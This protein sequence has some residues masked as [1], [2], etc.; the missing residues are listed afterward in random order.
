MSIAIVI[1][2]I[3]IVYQSL[4]DFTSATNNARLATFFWAFS[5]V[6]AGL[7]ARFFTT[8][9]Q[10]E[11]ES[12][13]RARY[14]IRDIIFNRTFLSLFPILLLALVLRVVPIMNRGLQ[15]DEWYWLDSAKYILKGVVVSPF[16]FIGD[17]PT[18]LPAYP[19][20][21][22]LLIVRNA[23][24]AVRLIGVI[25]SLIAISLVYFFVKKT[26]GFTAAVCGALLMT[27][28][29]WDIHMS[30][31]GYLNVNIS[32]MLV[33]AILFLLHQVWEQKY[34]FWTLFGLA[35]LTAICIHLL[36]VPTFLAVPVGLVLLI[37]WMRRHNGRRMKEI[38]LFGLFFFIVMSPIIQKVI[39]YPDTISRHSDYLQQ[40]LHLSSEAET[41][42]DYYLGQFIL[43]HKDYIKGD[44]NVG[45][46][47]LWGIT[48]D[49]LVLAL[50]MAGNILIV[51]QV[52]RK[53]SHPFWLVVIFTFS[54]QL[55]MPFVLLY[56]T[57]SVW[58]A[59]PILP[60]VYLIAIFVLVEISCLMKWIARK[61]MP[62]RKNLF[63]VFMAVNLAL[64]F[65]INLPW[66][67]YFFSVYAKPEDTY[68]NTT[69]HAAAELIAQKIPKGSVIYM[70]EE[71]C[72][73]L[74]SILYDSTGDQYHFVKVQSED[75]LTGL[76]KGDYVLLFNSRNSGYFLADL[77]VMLEQKLG[78]HQTEMVSPPYDTLP[79]LY[80]IKK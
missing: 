31:L 73:P 49:P 52:L 48:F 74:V 77:Q 17:Y 69:C 28:S 6:L 63:T 45:T 70:A 68:E 53:K 21:F 34:T 36:Y 80:L 79:V 23:M 8:Y 56:R 71:L 47:G 64:Y 7:S 16:A 5:V 42:L 44:L 59:Y 78:E 9:S 43:V 22:L 18:N 60:L 58:R 39:Q 40:N 57:E 19:L 38:V 37:H 29:A 33:A 3:A 67:G 65:M 54:V 46:Q 41:P 20:A 76:K 35:F 50:S 26:L 55:L 13:G 72:F 75:S 12:E 32:P 66:F 24:L 61:A 10:T 14:S 27:F 25:Y 1:N 11:T 15:L 2:I 4:G 62:D 30:G 51:I